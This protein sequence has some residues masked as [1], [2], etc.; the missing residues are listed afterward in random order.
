[1]RS[2]NDQ[3]LEIL[4]TQI[5][6]LRAPLELLSKRFRKRVEHRKASSSA[7]TDKESGNFWSMCAW[8]HSLERIQLFLDQNFNYIETMGL[9]AVTRYIF[10]LTIWLRLLAADSQYGLVYYY[11]LLKNQQDFYEALE[12]NAQRE[13]AFLEKVE[14]TEK[15]LLERAALETLQIA[16]E[17]ARTVDASQIWSRV[18]DQID[19]DASRKF[20]L[21]AEQARING[22][23]FQAHL[24]AAQILPEHRKAIEDIKQELDA[25]QHR[26]SDHLKKLIKK[27]WN[28]KEQAQKVGMEAEYEFI[29]LF[30]SLLMHAKPASI[31]TD[32]QNLGPTEIE[33]FLK[34]IRVRLL[35][36]IE[37]AE[38][39]L[40]NNPA[41]VQ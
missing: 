40:A 26:L 33:S 27:H 37:M 7:Y 3:T 38:E 8:E 34:Y 19:R 31:T 11:Q 6:D 2:N 14:E 29:Y 28:W 16:D 21:Y 4:V 41:V 36:I 5:R 23:G 39:P 9:L 17:R 1:V 35:D 25:F 15:A 32:Q 10:E 24:I 12:K 30:A 22:Y 18:S 20:S 13:I